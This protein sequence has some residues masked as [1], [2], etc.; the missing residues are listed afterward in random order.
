[1]KSSLMYLN[2]FI[3]YKIYVTHPGPE[4]AVETRLASHLLS[5]CLCFWSTVILNLLTVP[6][7]NY[8]SQKRMHSVQL[9]IYQGE[10]KK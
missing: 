1:M 5:F 4:L 2:P 6:G 3:L 7:C 10:K 8:V 9:R